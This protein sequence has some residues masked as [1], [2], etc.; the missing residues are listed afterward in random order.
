MTK[1]TDLMDEINQQ[2]KEPLLKMGSDPSFRVTYL[3][4]NVLPIDMLLQGGIP[5]GRFVT[6]TGD[7]STMNAVFG[8]AITAQP[9]NRL[10]FDSWAIFRN[11]AAPRTLTPGLRSDSFTPMR[12][13]VVLHA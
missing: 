8:I 13:I 1:A 5:R 2:L 4:T 9:M 6:L 7:F 10:T 12:L 11:A 3:P